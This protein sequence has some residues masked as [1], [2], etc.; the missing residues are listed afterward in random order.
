MVGHGAGSIEKDLGKLK[1]KE[2]ARSHFDIW[3]L[4]QCWTQ[5]EGTGGWFRPEGPAIDHDTKRCEWTEH[6]HDNLQDAL[7][8]R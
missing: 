6:T 2:I 1:F 5:V 3:K 7:R 4:S 8:R